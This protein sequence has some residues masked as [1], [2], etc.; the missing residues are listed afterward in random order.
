MGARLEAFLKGAGS[1]LD[2][3]AVNA[4]REPTFIQDDAEA[5]RKDWEAIGMDLYKVMD[6]FG[7]YDEDPPRGKPRR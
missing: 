5:I 4:S 3:F 7:V 6:Q 1:V 2:I